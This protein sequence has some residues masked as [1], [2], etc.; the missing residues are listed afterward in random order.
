MSNHDATSTQ[1]NLT[2][3]LMGSAE[4]AIRR[5]SAA[6]PE[7]PKQAYADAMLG[8][9][10]QYESFDM[11]FALIAYNVQA[12]HDVSDY[13]AR[14]RAMQN[15]LQPFCSEYG[16]E[17]NRPL[18]APHRA[19]YLDFYEQA[20]GQ[21]WPA[22][23]PARTESRWINT[24]R[25]WAE[26]MIKNLQCA[27]MSAMDRAKYNLGYHWSVEY[28]SIGEFELLRD[29][30]QR[31][32]V[33]APYLQSHCDVE[34]EHASCAV[35]AIAEFVPADDPL[36]LRGIREHEYDLVG[37][38]TENFELLQAEKA[39]WSGAKAHAGR[40]ESYQEATA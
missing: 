15:L 36:V 17:A 38:Y 8:M 35:M 23:Y 28:L 33:S 5:F 10:Y 11:M 19:L 37:F 18:G 12:T 30:W 34:P 32:G 21:K 2:S 22:V 40:K 29:G 26:R 25:Y 1:R 14:F 24:G 3:L 4:A 16:I 13:S 27:D 39:R 31:A 6:I 20:T 9:G 7:L